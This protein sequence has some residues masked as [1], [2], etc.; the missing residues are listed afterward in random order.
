[1]PLRLSC[2]GPLPAG[3]PP[4][5]MC[6]RRLGDDS[7]PGGP[8]AGGPAARVRRPD[9]GGTNRKEASCI[10]DKGSTRR[11]V[12]S[13]CTIYIRA[14][15][16]PLALKS[17][18]IELP[19]TALSAFGSMD[20]AY[21]P[22]VME[23]SLRVRL[24]APQMSLPQPSPLISSSGSKP[25]RAP[26]MQQKWSSLVS[27]SGSID[28]CSGG[29]PV[30]RCLLKPIGPWCH[31]T[32]LPVTVAAARTSCGHGLCDTLPVTARCNTLAVIEEVRAT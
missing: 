1:M 10:S 24:Q 15:R 20:C 4:F 14:S 9:T 3:S 12:A 23:S 11:S 30:V 17:W 25:K 29:V 13:A 6:H 28:P 21:Q 26:H 16:Q 8:W 18:M 22:I 7:L 31:V 2:A 19:L 27:S 5:E 32:R